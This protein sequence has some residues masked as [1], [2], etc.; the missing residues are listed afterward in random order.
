MAVWCFAGE[1]RPSLHQRT[2]QPGLAPGLKNPSGES[3]TCRPQAKIT[4]ERKGAHNRGGSHGM[5]P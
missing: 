2:G 4:L 5:D 1:G 3:P